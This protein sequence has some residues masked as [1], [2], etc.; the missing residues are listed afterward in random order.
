MTT[1]IPDI[2]LQRLDAEFQALNQT[3][4]ATENSLLMPPSILDA[5]A[6][7]LTLPIKAPNPTTQANLR[8]RGGKPDVIGH[9]II[10]Q[11]TINLT[12]PPGADE[13]TDLIGVE[14]T[15]AGLLT[16]MGNVRQAAPPITAPPLSI[17][18]PIDISNRIDEVPIIAASLPTGTLKAGSTFRISVRGTVQV[19]GVAGDSGDL[20]FRPYIGANV[21][22]QTFKMAMHTAGAG[23][24]V[25]YLEV[26]ATVRTLGSAGTYVSNGYGR[27][28]FTSADVL[29][30]DVATLVPSATAAVVDTN[31]AS[32]VVKLAAQWGKAKTDN[33][34]F[35]GVA[36]IAQIA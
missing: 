15:D 32:P 30:P 17:T 24:A 16:R 8:Y 2:E 26:D 19:D 25:F 20:T 23:P 5:T 22:M 35:I 11:L 28:E 6:G 21:A 29:T 7:T 33:K 12:V 10:S 18:A 3:F 36:T 1:P 34:L 31:A 27:I 9:A 13:V 14:L 4:G